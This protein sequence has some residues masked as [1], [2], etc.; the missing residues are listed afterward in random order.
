MIDYDWWKNGPGPLNPDYKP[1]ASEVRRAV[2]NSMVSDEFY[3]NHTR[4]ECR[5]EWQKRYDEEIKK[6]EKITLDN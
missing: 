3:A 4:E 1:Y 5:V 6:Y 2:T